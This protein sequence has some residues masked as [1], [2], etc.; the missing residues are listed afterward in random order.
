MIEGWLVA[1]RDHPERPAAMQRYVL[2]MLALRLDWK[3]GKGFASTAQLAADADVTP[4]TV[5]RATS[6]AR[7]AELLLQTR[8][9]HRLGNGQ[10]A[11]SEWQL[12]QRLTPEPLTSQGLNGQI[13]RDQQG[14]LNGSA[15]THHQESSTS[16]S[17]SS[18]RASAADTV[19]AAFADVT[20]EEIETIIETVRSKYQP[21][22]LPG[23]IATLAAKG[24]LRRPCDQQAATPHSQ[25]CRGGESG[26]CGQDWCEC[27][28]HPR[29]PA[30]ATS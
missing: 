20:D 18:P 24:E 9:G 17:S 16:Q 25:A 5:K 11:A 15:E 8:R 21:R 2:T 22:N 30:E 23:Y 13:S 26:G 7:K 29:K 12:T 6:W 3:S 4:P 28:C 27:R 10:V 1:I 19:R 14:N